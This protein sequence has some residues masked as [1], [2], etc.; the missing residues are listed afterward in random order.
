MLDESI[1]KTFT[2]PA[3]IEALKTDM[4]TNQSGMHFII[5]DRNGVVRDEDDLFKA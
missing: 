3:R 2:M 5:A 4:Y 1:R